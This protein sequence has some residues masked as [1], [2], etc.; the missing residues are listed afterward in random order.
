MNDENE[1]SLPSVWPEI[2]QQTLAMGFDMPSEARTAA[3]LTVLA[4]SKPGGRFLELGTGTGLA[5]AALLAGM[6]H[7]AELVTVD[8]DP[9]VQDVARRA[10]GHD[11]RL[12]FRLED[13]LAYIESQPPR[14]FDLVFADAMPGKYEGLEEALRLVRE[15]GIYVGDD[16]L[17]Q[18]NWPEGHQHRV[19]GLVHQL[20]ALKDWSMMSI[21]WGSGYVVAVRRGAL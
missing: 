2:R 20:Q 7:D 3:L 13:G 9:T 12:T 21:A 6:S 8:V 4:A 5:T 19:N 15:G 18:A 14:S 11:D 10:L 16:M 1:H 17:P